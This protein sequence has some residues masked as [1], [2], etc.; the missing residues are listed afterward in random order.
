MFARCRST[1]HAR[2]HLLSGLVS[3][4]Y[5]SQAVRTFCHNDNREQFAAVMAIPDK[6]AD[7]I[8]IDRLL[9]N[10]DNVSATGDSRCNRNPARIAPHHFT[11]NDAIMSLRC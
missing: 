9:G 11:D 5:P 1:G 10:E 6:C 3:H 7:M 2:T 4:S 8:E